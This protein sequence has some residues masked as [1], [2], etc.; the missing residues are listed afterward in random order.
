MIQEAFGKADYGT[1]KWLASATVPEK[2]AGAPRLG[3]VHVKIKDG[4]AIATDGFRM[5]MAWLNSNLAARLDGLH[6]IRKFM[7]RGEIEI[8]HVEAELRFPDFTA[9]IPQADGRV[10]IGVNPKFLADAVANLEDAD[11]KYAVLSFHPTRVDRPFE[12]FILD[13]EAKQE[14]YVLIMPKL[15]KGKDWS[16]KDLKRP[17]SSREEA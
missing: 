12:I 2:E 3:M 5:H 8:E 14:R 10:L 11:D 13:K 16:E 4:V 15:N 17:R 7:T 1:L 9:V 6:R